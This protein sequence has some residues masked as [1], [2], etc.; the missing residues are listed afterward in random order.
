MAILVLMGVV[1]AILFATLPGVGEVRDRLRSAEPGWIAVA[2]LCSLGSVLSFVA[3]LLGAFDRI[4]P[5]RRGLTLGLAEQGAN[6]LLPA[7][8]AGGPAFGTFVMRRAGVPPEIATERHVALFLITSAVG[9][10][11]LT[12]FGVLEAVG[13]LPG[14]ASL[15]ATLVPAVA[16]VVAIAGVAALSLMPERPQPDPARRPAHVVW[17]LR[18]FLR[19]GVRT[20]LVLLREHDALL[21]GGAIGYYAL[22]I[23]ALGAAFEA[24][25]GGGPPLGIFV[26]AYTIG[27][28]GAFLPTPGGVGGTDG[29][30]IGMFAAFG[31]PLDLATAAVLS[32]RVFQLGLPAI[33]GAISLVQIRGTLRNGAARD[34]VAARFTHLEQAGRTP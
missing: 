9:F 15:V 20:S 7:G 27:H 8:G 24:F 6:V 33:L 34:V 23:G 30:L 21:I 2:A 25:G 3:A 19:G 11:A 26:L 10:V 17:R 29:G 18:G 12:L 22:D 16:G 32:Y 13:A 4:V 28:A 5:F 31:A 1:V 14:D